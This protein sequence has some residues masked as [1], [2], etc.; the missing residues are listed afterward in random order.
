MVRDC[1]ASSSGY[2]FGHARV[3]SFSI[4]LVFWT[5][6]FLEVLFAVWQC[7]VPLILEV[8]NRIADENEA[9]RR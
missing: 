3:S 2:Y 5:S 7:H 8:D 6:G 9:T 1:A 4:A